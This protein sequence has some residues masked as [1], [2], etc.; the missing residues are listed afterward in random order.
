MRWIMLTIL[1]PSILLTSMAISLS[2]ATLL[3]SAFYDRDVNGDGVLDLLDV[4]IVALSYNPNG[5]VTNPRADINGDRVVNLFDIVLIASALYTLPSTVTP[6][7]PVPPPIAPQFSLFPEC[8]YVLREERIIGHYAIR[9]WRKSNNEFYCDDIVTISAFGQPNVQIET[10]DSIDSLTGRD[11][12]GEGH[13]DV[14]IHTDSGG[15]HCCYSALVYDLGETLTKVLETP[16]SN[17]K[18][19][20]SDLDADGIFEAVTCDDLFAYRYCS[21]AGSP[22]PTVILAHVP[23]LGY[24]PA[25][26][27]FAWFYVGDIA[28]D[29]VQAELATPGGKG[30]FDGTTKCAVLALVL[31]YLYAGF[32]ERAWTE[33]YRLYPYPDR[34]T[35][36]AE[37][38]EAVYHSPLF[39][40]R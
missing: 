4:V 36:R 2:S 22:M 21:F 32:P 20:F 13:P 33:F 18:T 11:I 9:L 8:T 24:G 19:T 34:E 26:P 1:L 7:P 37:I 10:V 38:E 23:G 27:R 16:S 5:P 29:T 40:L 31:D 6:L 3:S 35:F 14:I 15:A 28:R 25:S 30:E 17:C 12:T 39:A